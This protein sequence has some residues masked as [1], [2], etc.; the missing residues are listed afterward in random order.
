VPGEQH[1]PFAA[2]DLTSY[3]GD[4]FAESAR[5]V[6]AYPDDLPILAERLAHIELPI[7]IIAA[8]HDG[9]VPPSNAEFLNEH[10]PH[11]RLTLLDTDHFTWEDAAPEYAALPIDWIG[12]GYAR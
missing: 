10:L 7:Q 9:L 2:A 12:G 11:S 6:R 8:R 5:Y 3:A 1:G 4:R